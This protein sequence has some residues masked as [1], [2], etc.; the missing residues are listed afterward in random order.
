MC[1]RG[2][3]GDW[4]QEM[5]QRCIPTPQHV[6]TGSN[7]I[8][9]DLLRPAGRSSH[10]RWVSNLDPKALGATRLRVWLPLWLWSSD[11]PFSRRLT[12]LPWRCPGSWDGTSGGCPPALR[13]T[14]GRRCGSSSLQSPVCRSGT[15][16]EGSGTRIHRR[17]RS[18]GKQTTHLFRNLSSEGSKVK[19]SLIVLGQRQQRG[20]WQ[21][22]GTMLRKTMVELS[23]KNL[24]KH[25]LDPTSEPW[26]TPERIESNLSMSGNEF[27][28]HC[29]WS[30]LSQSSLSWWWH[31]ILR[32]CPK[33]NDHRIIL[34]TITRESPAAKT[35]QE[36]WEGCLK[37]REP[38]TEPW[39][40]T[41]S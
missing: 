9:P 26:G 2:L 18:G 11:W 23:Y 1:C 21:E 39:G 10:A 22:L 12:F 28:L 8:G 27:M 33:Q 7:R 41:D 32:T 4:L 19:C 3:H 14:G 16:P 40:P 34:E 24:L 5:E 35:N 37:R 6:K 17:P 36:N 38:S 29:D 13:R 20:E 31:F 25:G 15:S 30:S